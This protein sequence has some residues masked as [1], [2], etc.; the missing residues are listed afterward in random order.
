MK[1]LSF[2][3]SLSEYT[4]PSI[5]SIPNDLCKSGWNRFVVSHYYAIHVSFSSPKKKRRSI[6]KKRRRNAQNAIAICPF[7]YHA[8]PSK[9]KKQKKKIVSSYLLLSHFLRNITR[10]PIQSSH[11][12]ICSRLYSRC[13]RSITP[14]LSRKDLG[15]DDHGR[16]DRR[17]VE[18]RVSDGF[19]AVHCRSVEA[20]VC[21][22][23]VGVARSCSI[24]CRHGAGG[25]W[26]CVV[27]AIRGLGRLVSR[28]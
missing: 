27:V 8:M 19:G 14:L 11:I 17:S 26:D 22:V 2:S 18:T 13:V 28:W 6:Q 7:V 3:L 23:L 12:T 20:R 25:E 16:T 5:A 21:K 9:P 10:S 15:R 24:S 1:I 4:L